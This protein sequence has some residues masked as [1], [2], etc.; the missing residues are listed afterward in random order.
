MTFNLRGWFKVI[1]L[2]LSTS[3]ARTTYRRP[4]QDL[5]IT[6]DPVTLGTKAHTMCSLACPIKHSLLTSSSW[7]TPSFAIWGYPSETRKGKNL[8]KEATPTSRE[9]AYKLQ[10]FKKRRKP[11]I[12]RT[13]IEHIRS[14]TAQ[15][16][17]NP[18]TRSRK[19]K[20]I[21]R[22]RVRSHKCTEPVMVWMQERENERVVD[23]PFCCWQNKEWKLW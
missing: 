3:S 12:T 18:E 17:H 11:T 16:T 7:V 9:W 4:N 8:P 1:T 10:D 20:R 21:G 2:I 14:N 22:S 13:P 19:Q 15:E 6:D 23:R 5:S